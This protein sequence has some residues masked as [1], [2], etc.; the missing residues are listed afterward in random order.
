MFW[1]A[2]L[3]TILMII[4][5]CLIIRIILLYR[6][7]DEVCR[8]LNTRLNID[9]NTLITVSSG[10]R[11]IRRLAAELNTQ[12]RQLKQERRRL[13]SGDLEL[14][15]AVANI[16]HDLRTP[17]TAICGYLDL[18]KR[19]DKS[20]TVNRY[21]SVI[22]NRTEV[23]KKLTEELFRYSIIT[24]VSPDMKYEDLALNS[25]LEESISAYYASLKNSGITPV[26]TIPEGKIQRRLDREALSRIF[27][28]IITNVIKYSD[29]DLN[30]TLSKSGE[31]DFIN[32][33]SQL[34]EIQVGKLFDRFYTVE[35]AKKSTGLGLSIA[36]ILTEQMNGTISAHYHN[37][38]LN[39]RIVFSEI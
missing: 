16:S 19:E 35:N 15:E 5:I 2:V 18:L 37:G 26:I 4:I 9:T 3:C 21:L 11:H 22:E 24:S 27:S 12:L 28:N 33:S 8:E 38:K 30:I 32:S 31:I 17:L 7:I 10:D 6:T 39:I 23:M 1:L 36:K 20:D 13:Q 14:K 34:D 29:G 25:V